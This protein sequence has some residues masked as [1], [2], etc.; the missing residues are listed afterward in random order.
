[1]HPFL[2]KPY[3]FYQIFLHFISLVIIYQ[4]PPML[5]VALSF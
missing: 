5:E 1:M 2:H 3:D 4:K